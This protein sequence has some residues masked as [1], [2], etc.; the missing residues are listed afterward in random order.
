MNRNAAAGHFINQNYAHSKHRV[1]FEDPS[2][3]VPASHVVIKQCVRCNRVQ[4]VHISEL[5]HF[6]TC[7]E[8]LE[9]RYT[10]HSLKSA[11]VLKN[12]LERMVRQY[13]FDKMEPRSKLK[14]PAS[15]ARSKFRR[16]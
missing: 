11:Q 7:C 5:E 12:R 1:R 10:R 9:M 6:H 8:G 13:D 2:P 14:K 15:K 3:V 4:H 16:R